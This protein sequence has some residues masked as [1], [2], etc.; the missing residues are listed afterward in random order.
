LSP[1]RA[2]WIGCSRYF[3]LPAVRVLELQPVMLVARVDRLKADLDIDL[4]ELPR[5]RE[6]TDP[7]GRRRLIVE[8]VLVDDDHQP[9]RLPEMP[10]RAV[11]MLA[12]VLR[13]VDRCF[14]DGERERLPALLDE[15]T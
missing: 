12:G 13:G 9:R 14:G 6:F 8:L 10:G 1:G 7:G 2:I 3:E 5:E 15:F 4:V 11:V